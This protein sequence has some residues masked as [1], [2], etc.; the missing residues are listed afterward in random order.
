MC[1]RLT[2]RLPMH[3]R[4]FMGGISWLLVSAAVPWLLAGCRVPPPPPPEQLARGMEVAPLAA[5]AIITITGLDPS[6]P[7]PPLPPVRPATPADQNTT[8]AQYFRIDAQLTTLMAFPERIDETAER[9]L[10]AEIN[11]FLQRSLPEFALLQQFRPAAASHVADLKASISR[12]RAAANPRDASASIAHA[13]SCLMQVEKQ[14]RM[15]SPAIR[16]G[17][18]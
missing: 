14:T 5:S 16:R 1:S 12:A 6:S 8:E 13:R 3:Q 10:I 4:H 18:P 7:G 15:L 11:S 17:T 9:A 2:K